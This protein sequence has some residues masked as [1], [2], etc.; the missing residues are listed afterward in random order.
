[1]PNS[2]IT[3]NQSGLITW[4]TSIEGQVDEL[5]AIDRETEITERRAA[6]SEGVLI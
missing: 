6:L 2:C 3:Y 4:V 5:G 1:M